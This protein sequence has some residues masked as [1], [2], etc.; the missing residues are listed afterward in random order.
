MR[1]PG[2]GLALAALVATPAH[3]LDVVVVDAAAAPVDAVMVTVWP[4]VP[5]VTDKSDNGYAE[6]GALQQTDRIA[7]AFTGPTGAAHLD[8]AEHAGGWTVRARRPGFDDVVVPV[9]D[10]TVPLTLTMTAQTDP[11]KLAQARPANTWA[12][13]VDLGSPELN[14]NYRMQCSFCH[15]QGLSVMRSGKSEQGWSDTITRMIGYGSRLWS[16]AR[17]VAPAKLVAA[18]QDM[19]AHPEEVPESRPWD[20]MLSSARMEEW[21]VGDGMSQMHDMLVHPNGF[22]YVG[23]NTQD[24]LYEVNPKTG[25]FTVYKMPREPG[26]TLGGLFAA[27]LAAFPKHETYTSIHSLALSRKDGHLLLTPSTQRRIVE[28]D[29][30]TKA[31]SV[32]ELNDGLYPHTIRIDAQDRVWFTLALSN[33]VGMIDRATGEQ[34]FIDLPARSWKEAFTIH[35]VPLMFKLAEYGLPLSSLGIDEIATGTPLAYGIDITPDGVVWVA[36]LHANDL[37]RID[38]VTLAV[39]MIPFPGHGPRRL[40]TDADGNLWITAFGDSAVV[41]YDPAARKFDTF[42]MPTMPVGSDTPYSINVDRKRGVVWVTGTA[43]DTLNALDIRTGAWSVFPLPRRLFFT[44]DIEVADDGS[45]YSSNGAFPAWFIEGGQPTLI[46][47][48][49]PWAD[50]T[51]GVTP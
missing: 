18:Y 38:P 16:E 12:S 36:R 34:H 37:A 2:L 46:H 29:P 49:P 11:M 43:S 17:A 3:A 45:V 19:M 27:R 39:E 14:R 24:R 50:A 4:T 40:R 41:R 32:H 35:I 10:L 44:R 22:V 47:V 15:Q 8:V 31:F 26:D 9:A 48:T 21:P 1:R 28:F 42:P 7:T 6:V 5:A 33:Q 13:L 30:A 51:T 20:A 25:E 23:D